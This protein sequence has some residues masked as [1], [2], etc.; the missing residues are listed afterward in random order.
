MNA[1]TQAAFSA[2]GLPTTAT[3]EEVAAAHRELARVWHPDRFPNDPR[4]KAN[5]Q[6]RL[7]RINNAR[8]ILKT[9]FQL[10]ARLYPSR[11]GEAQAPPRAKPGPDLDPDRE[12]K[13]VAA[14]SITFLIIIS[15]C[16]FGVM[17]MYV[18]S[19]FAMLAATL[20][21]VT[22]VSALV[23]FMVKLTERVIN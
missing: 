20:L 18:S 7:A 11:N 15:A 12:R 2:L 22:S 19:P 3:A 1:E 17:F 8:D 13:L 10:M 21:C 6:T 9:H 14:V 5:A 16:S 4:M 23:V